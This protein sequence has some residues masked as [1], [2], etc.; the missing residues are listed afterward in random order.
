[1]WWAG[2]LGRPAPPRATPCRPDSIPVCRQVHSVWATRL[3]HVTPSASSARP[4]SSGRRYATPKVAAGRTEQ[5]PSA[6]RRPF[7]AVRAPWPP[8]VAPCRCCLTAASSTNLVP[9]LA[10]SRFLTDGSVVENPY[11]NR[12]TRQV[13]G[14]ILTGSLKV[15]KECETTAQVRHALRT[16]RKDL[17]HYFNPIEDPEDI[18]E[19]RKADR[20]QRELLVK[21]QMLFKQ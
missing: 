4:S 3:G 17:Q 12:S 18:K 21:T 2:G 11:L 19:R 13:A 9:V 16:A 20:R 6:R 15:L 14:D 7:L 1:M 5:R 10:P 8:L